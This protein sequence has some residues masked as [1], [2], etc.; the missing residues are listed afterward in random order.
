MYGRSQQ[1]GQSLLLSMRTDRG[2]ANRRRAPRAVCASPEAP[3]LYTNT[4]GSNQALRVWATWTTR[5]HS[6]SAATRRSRR[7]LPSLNPPA[8]RRPIPR[9]NRAQ[10]AV[11]PGSTAATAAGIA[12]TGG[13]TSPASDE[14]ATTSMHG[15]HAKGEMTDA[16]CPNDGDSAHATLAQARAVGV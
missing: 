5:E 13:R 16:S 7:P 11:W 3:Q 12:G 4:I 8:Q 14:N 10:R 2:L 9:P 1:T 6:L 15:R